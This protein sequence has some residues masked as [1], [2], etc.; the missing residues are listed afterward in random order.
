MTAYP[1][2][3]RCGQLRATATGE[4]TRVSVCHCVDC[5]KHSGSAFAARVRLALRNAAR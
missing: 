2:S 5:Q 3:C 1:A 4:P